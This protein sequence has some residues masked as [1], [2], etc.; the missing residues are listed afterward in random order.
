[1]VVI[2]ISNW[3]KKLVLF[4]VLAVF[5]VSLGM[6]INWYLNP[7]D[8]PAVAP[9]DKKLHEDV[10]TQPLKVQGQPTTET[11]QLLQPGTISS[12]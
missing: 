11:I 10:L 12:E 5:L 4:L 6:S 8:N 9:S 7:L 3:K 1:M 2:T